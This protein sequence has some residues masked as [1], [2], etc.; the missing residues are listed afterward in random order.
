[1][2]AEQ[3]KH[4]G[5]GRSEETRDPFSMN[6]DPEEAGNNEVCID[7]EGSNAGSSSNDDLFQ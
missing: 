3:M 7:D 5:I 4:L 1:M 2:L 6:A